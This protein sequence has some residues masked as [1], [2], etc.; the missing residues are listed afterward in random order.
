MI[1]QPESFPAR[2]EVDYPEQ[3]SRLTTLLRVIWIIPIFIILGL[4]SGGG[5]SS[6]ANETGEVARSSG[7]GISTGLFLATALMIVG[8][9]TIGPMGVVAADPIAIVVGAAVV[10]LYFR[11]SLSERGELG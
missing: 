3:L 11:R 5:E 1:A 10:A 7:G 6:F 8:M 9:R 4:V 2:L